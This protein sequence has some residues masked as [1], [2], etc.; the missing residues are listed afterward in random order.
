MNGTWRR[1]VISMSCGSEIRRVRL[2]LDDAWTGDE[3]ER[4]AVPEED[5]P[6]LHL[7]HGPHYKGPP[8]GW[9]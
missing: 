7:R 5:V 4:M 9:R 8:P 1:P 2:T 6:D 3:H